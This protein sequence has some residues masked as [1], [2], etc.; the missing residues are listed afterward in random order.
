MKK[1]GFIKRKKDRV[2]LKRNTFFIFHISSLIFVSASAETPTELFNPAAR[3]YIVGNTS[4]ASNLVT[5]A[6]NQ[7]PTDEKLQKLKELIDQQQQDQ[8]NQQNQDQQDQQQ[9]QDQQNQDQKN[10]QDQS[11]QEQQNQ[12]D[13]QQQEEQSQDQQD[14]DSQQ[15]E[16]REPQEAQPSEAQPHQAGE[17]S[18]EEA[19]HL[20]DAMKMNEKDQRTDLRPILGQPVRV[21]KDW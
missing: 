18:P 2:S 1:A 15:S 21:D 11:Q 14:Q 10:Q 9:T 7:Y 16:E 3:E 13:Q 17:M 6:L 19:Q 20:L 12:D 5:E 4:V 8:Q